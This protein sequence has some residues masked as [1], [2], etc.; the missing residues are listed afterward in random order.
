MILALDIGNTRTKLAVFDEKEVFFLEHATN[1]DTEWAIAAK[2]YP[3]EKIVISSVV[4]S[5][6]SAWLE[7]FKGKAIQFIG[8]DSP[9]GFQVNVEMPEKVGVD[10]LLGLEAALTYPGAVIVV[11]AGTATKW[12]ILEGVR[13]RA[14]PGGAI[15]PG[16]G[17]SYKALIASTE[18]LPEIELS[19]YSPIVGYNTETA[20]R[21]GVV[22]GFAA[23]VDGMIL[24]IFEERKLPS[25]TSVVATGGYSSFL[26]NR[27]RFITHYRPHLVLEGI[28][29]IAKK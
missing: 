9:W 21:S 2:K 28:Y 17:I 24:K 26:K 7:F 20:V 8:A 16:L 25:T 13:D 12:N 15:A 10:R 5:A 18:L 29:A 27:A 4:P 14:F 3:I 6:H 19:K 11:D 22:H 1:G 23:Q